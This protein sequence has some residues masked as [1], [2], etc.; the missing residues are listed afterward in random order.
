MNNSGYVPKDICFDDEGRNKLIKG[1]TT[2]SK[3]VKSTLGPRG[4]TV[5]IE[6]LQQKLKD[7]G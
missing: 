6:S 2:I 3:A 7:N 1:I 4:K 5:L